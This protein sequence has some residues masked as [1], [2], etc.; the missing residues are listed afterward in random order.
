MN[1]KL[2]KFKQ[3]LKQFMSQLCAHLNNLKNQLLKRFHEHQR[4]SHLFFA[5]HFYIRDVIIRKH[6]NCT[7]K[8]QIEKTILLIERIELNLDMSN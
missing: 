6:K 2:K 7:T 4:A 5:L 8:M 3:R 1:Q